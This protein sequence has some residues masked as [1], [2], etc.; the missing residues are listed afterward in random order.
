MTADTEKIFE[1]DENVTFFVWLACFQEP[2]HLKSECHPNNTHPDG[3][4]GRRD[5]F[6]NAKANFSFTDGENL[7][8]LR[9]WFRALRHFVTAQ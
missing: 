9:L 5:I 6:Q 8:Q 3:N 1:S 4:R 7:T 2:W